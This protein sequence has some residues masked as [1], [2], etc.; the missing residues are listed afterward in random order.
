MTHCP[1]DNVA[2]I[3]RTGIETELLRV[4]HAE[5]VKILLAVESGSRAWGFPSRDSDYDVRLI[6]QRPIQ[7]YLSVVPRRDV[8]EMPIDAILDISGWDLRKALT[9][10]LKSNAI[11]L[12][13]LASPIRYRDTGDVPDRIAVFAHEAANPATLAYHYDHQAR[14]SL[15]EIQESPS[16]AKLKSYCYA[17]RAALAL[18]WLKERDD[19]APINLHALMSGTRRSGSIDDAIERLVSRRSTSSEQDAT[20]RL[21]ILDTFLVEVLLGGVS[22]DLKP[23]RSTLHEQA[24]ALFG[25]II[26]GA[27]ETAS[28]AIA[29]G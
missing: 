10:S 3:M 29:L 15:A 28:A 13:W 17:V 4:E 12:E 6:Y 11:L 26:L 8:I 16:G 21:P 9:L 23:G 19:P 25:S 1:E 27:R 24:N 18:R 7:D 20:D 2:A 5:G 22:S 14:R